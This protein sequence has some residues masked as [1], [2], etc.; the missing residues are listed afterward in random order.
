VGIR[1]A[2]RSVARHGAAPLPPKTL[3][4]LVAAVAPGSRPAVGLPEFDD[5][6][7]VAPHPDDE[8]I[9]CGGLL[10][11]CSRQSRRVTVVFATDG[12]DLLI[13][14]KPGSLGR[15]RRA[16]GTAA[17][18][19]LGATAVFLGLPDG[20]LHRE[21]DALASAIG[22]SIADARAGLV[23]LP[24]FGDANSDHQAVNSAFA[25]A[26][27]DVHVWGYEVWTPLPAN[28]VVDITTAVDDK[29]R[30]IAAH[31]ADVFIDADA[32]LGLNRYRA[33]V[34]RMNGTHAEAFY[35][36]SGDEYRRRVLDLL[37]T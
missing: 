13:A 33:A 29:R 24:W 17:C 7:V 16:Q 25:R 27:A 31:T 9:G 21:V 30:A 15:R 20:G 18:E 26:S 3:R 4:S 19:I 23:V 12:E 10:A 36:A 32:L 2:L 34:A 8:S 6:V 22:R 28:R 14:D 5:I 11:L 35:E 1:R 37:A